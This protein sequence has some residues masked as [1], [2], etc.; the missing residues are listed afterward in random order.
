MLFDDDDPTAGE[1]ERRSVV[2]PA[3]RSPHAKYLTR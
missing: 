3:Q 1:A 2:A